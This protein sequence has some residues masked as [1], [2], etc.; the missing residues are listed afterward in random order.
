[1]RT[2]PYTDPDRLW[3]LVN[4]LVDGS[5]SGDAVA[6]TAVG[7]MLNRR[8]ASVIAERDIA[9]MRYVICFGQRELILV[10]P[11][12]E[13]SFFHAVRGRTE[14]FAEVQRF[15]ARQV[16][17]VHFP[18]SSEAPHEQFAGSSSLLE[19]RLEGTAPIWWLVIPAMTNLDNVAWAAS[20]YVTTFGAGS[21]GS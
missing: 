18:S 5:R 3:T 12:P 4:G 21:S 10:S 7:H 20:S 14:R 8:S 13:V 9:N 11:R 6:A 1:M 19:I 2:G 16:T 15:P 17:G